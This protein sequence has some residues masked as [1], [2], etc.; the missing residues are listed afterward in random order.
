MNYQGKTLETN[1][2]CKYSTNR[3]ESALGTAEWVLQR[4]LRSPTNEKGIITFV[5]QWITVA[6]ADHCWTL[7]NCSSWLFRQNSFTDTSLGIFN[8]NR[9]EGQRMSKGVRKW[10]TAKLSVLP[11]WEDYF[12]VCKASMKR[13]PQEQEKRKI[14]F[15]GLYNYIK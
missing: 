2:A 7:S 10:W 6:I 8:W 1:S 4:L 9:D 5:T 14:S 11:R 15:T 12:R 13:K 3:Q